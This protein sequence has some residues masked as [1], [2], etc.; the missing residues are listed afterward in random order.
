[1]SLFGDLAGQVLGNVLGGNTQ[2]SNPLLQI[3]TS[4][5]Q[6]HGGLDGL[7]T[8][9][10]AA[11]LG[12]QAASWVGTGPNKAI[13]ASQ[14]SSVLGNDVLEA[15]AGKFGLS[16]TQVSGGLAD[17]LPQ[18]IDKA[19]PGGSTQGADDVLQQGFSALE[20]LLRKPA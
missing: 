11:G 19:T 4:L 17:L 1:M 16:G 6:Q 7:L 2:G 13:D 8:Q 12:E 5:L 20:G 10:Q 3:A 9:F 15:L 14:L 18:L